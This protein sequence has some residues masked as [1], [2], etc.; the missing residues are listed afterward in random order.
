MA[1]Q[2]RFIGAHGAMHY[3][4]GFAPEVMCTCK[5]FRVRARCYH[6]LFVVMN[7]HKGTVCY[8]RPD[9]RS[10]VYE[11]AWTDAR[12][13]IPVSTSMQKEKLDELWERAVLRHA[14]W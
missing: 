11:F 10:P 2:T 1:Q 9:S 6:A 8:A 7:G 14:E 4:E 13:V 12:S 3:V 5:G